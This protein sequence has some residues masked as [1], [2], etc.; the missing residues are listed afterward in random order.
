MDSAAEDINPCFVPSVSSGS[1]LPGKVPAWVLD[2]AHA[3]YYLE[4]L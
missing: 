1:D 2:V 4:V 3:L